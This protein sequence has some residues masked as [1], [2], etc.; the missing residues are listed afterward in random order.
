[1]DPSNPVIA[2]SAI[3][4][5]E[6][7][8]EHYTKRGYTLA[9]KDW[10]EWKDLPA[11]YKYLGVKVDPKHVEGSGFLWK[12][13]GD[14]KLAVPA[15]LLVAMPLWMTGNLPGFDERLE[16]SLITILA[17]TVIS[18][19]V[20]PIFKNWRKSS[21]EPKIKG[22]YDAEKALNDEIS[23]TMSVF[24]SGGAIP[25]TMRVVNA[26]ERALRKL[27]ATAATHKA[28]IA[29]RD[30]MVAQLDYL[31]SLKGAAAGETGSAVVKAAGAAVEAAFAKDAALQQKSIE[32]AIKALKEGV[33]APADDSV[34]PAFASALAD[35]QKDAAKKAATSANPFT[36]A[37]NVE[38]FNKR[39]GFGADSTRAV[40]T[41]SVKSPLAYA[42]K[43]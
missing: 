34:T 3:P 21:L 29:A 36:Q 38:I 25:E 6:Y 32:A 40:G 11:P 23:H 19:E 18:K 37:S 5:R 33:V 13:M 31:V 30:A 4:W 12:A 41:T 10:T 8:N 27:E 26:A 35:A 28:Q 39:F 43:A 24:Q 14:W 22:L 17:G 16:L 2:P 7:K 1:M 9:E 42:R 20:A 15:A